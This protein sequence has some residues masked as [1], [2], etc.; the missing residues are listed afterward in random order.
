MFF[1]LRGSC[2][3][4]TLKKRLPAGIQGYPPGMGLQFNREEERTLLDAAVG[5]FYLP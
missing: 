5:E 4:P 3:R 1:V 2:N